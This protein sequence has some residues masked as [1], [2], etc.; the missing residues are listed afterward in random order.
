MTYNSY[1]HHYQQRAY[2][3]QREYEA[4]Q[5]RIAAQR[6]EAARRAAAAARIA[7]IETAMNQLGHYIEQQ[8]KQAEEADWQRR[9]DAHKAHAAAA[10]APPPA[11]PRFVPPPA[12]APMIGYRG[13]GTSIIDPN[14]RHIA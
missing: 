8:R 2:E 13:L 14:T 12:D 7:Q 4:Q 5:N 3:A 1:D 6:A 11:N 10:P 9:W